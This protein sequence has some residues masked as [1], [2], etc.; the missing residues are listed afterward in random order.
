[1]DALGDQGDVT[2]LLAQ[3]S[4]AELAALMENLGGNC[5]HTMAETFA[6]IDHDQPVCFLAYT[7][8]GWGTPIAGH[9]DNHG[10]LMT[11]TQMAEW[12]RSMGVAAGEEWDSLPPSR[13]TGL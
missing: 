4:D 1:M 2:A 12:Q 10:G 5:V 6:A 11:K 7:I 3:R 8:K 13:S 9:K